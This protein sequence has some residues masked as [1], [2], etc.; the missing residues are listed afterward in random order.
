MTNSFTQLAN[1]TSGL[2]KHAKKSVKHSL[3]PIQE[4]FALKSLLAAMEKLTPSISE[5]TIRHIMRK[6]ST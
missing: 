4:S 5:D 6:A 2:S 3:P 1:N